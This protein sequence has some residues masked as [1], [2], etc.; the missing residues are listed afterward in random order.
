MGPNKGLA[1]LNGVGTGGNPWLRDSGRGSTTSEAM[2]GEVREDEPVM[3]K[4]L[5][6]EKIELG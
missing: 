2:T 1:C 4:D 6:L 5:R 3:G